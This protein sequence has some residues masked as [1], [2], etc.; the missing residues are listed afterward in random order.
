MSE[1]KKSK[2]YTGV[3]FRDKMDGDRTYYITIKDEDRKVKFQKVGTRSQG[4]TEKIVSEKRSDTILKVNH[5]EI[6][7]SIKLQI[8]D[9][10]FLLD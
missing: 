3:Y 1:M 5:G 4:L 8:N 10:S 7:E 2:K 6:I 9:S